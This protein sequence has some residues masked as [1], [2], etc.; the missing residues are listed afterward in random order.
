MGNYNID[1]H[2]YIEISK[3]TVYLCFFYSKAQINSK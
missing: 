2:K 3:N 1:V